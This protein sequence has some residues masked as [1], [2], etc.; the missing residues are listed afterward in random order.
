MLDSIHQPLVHHRLP[1]GRL[2]LLVDHSTAQRRILAL[3]LQRKGYRVAEAGSLPD[4]MTLIQQE[5]PDIIISDWVL[6]A[7]TGLDF[8]RTLRKD[9]RRG[10][11]YFIL[12]TAKSTRQD[13][14]AGLAAGADAFLTK[15]ISGA[16]LLSQLSVAERI[17]TMEERLRATNRELQHAVDQLRETQQAMERDLCDARILQQRLVRERSGRFGEFNLSLLLRPAGH[18]GGD[19]V[20]FFPINARRVGIYAL[21]V[22]GHGVTS[23]LL[24]ARLAA[25]LSDSTDQNLAL[26]TT[27]LG[28]YE[29]RPP[30]ELLQILN[31]QM[32]EELRTDAY[33][34]MIYADLDVLNGKMKLVQA[35]HP[36]PFIQRADGR[37]EKIGQGGLPVGIMPAAPFEEIELYLGPG[38]RL[39]A[40]SDGITDCENSAGVPLGDEG[41]GAILRTNA[42]LHGEAFLE[43]LSWSVSTYAEGKR[44]DDVSAVLI[45]RSPSDRSTPL[46]D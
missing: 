28:L 1:S 12:L 32:L 30:G 29:A 10:Y 26:T 14:T 27:P 5:R 36:H 33:Y 45:E 41:L 38:D 39:I 34:T 16:E 40:V 19:M 22:S 23:A 25:Q 13:V 46:P 11:S 31:M 20:G 37:I 15:P 3:Q 18:I 43:S 8:C 17:L 44:S 4:A 6:P 42:T 24:T 7:G 35:G 21:D 9:D 2:V